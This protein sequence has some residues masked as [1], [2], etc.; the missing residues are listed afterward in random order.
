M[1]EELL[2][3][4]VAM[5]VTVPTRRKRKR[6]SWTSDE[7]RTFLESARSAQDPMY[8]VY[9]LILTIGLR[10]GEVLG[11][12]WNDVDLSGETLAV[13]HQ[14][15]RVHG[16]L[17]HRATK[18][19]ESEDSLPLVS[20][21]TAALRWQY[22]AQERAKRAAGEAWQ[23]GSWVFTT[24][25]GTPIEPRNFSRYFEARCEAA[26]VPRITVHDAR[27]TCATLLVDLDVHPRVIMR[28]LR[29]TQISMTMDIYAQASSKATREALRQLGNELD[30]PEAQLPGDGLEGHH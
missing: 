1:R 24:R 23:P 19:E 17:Y 9:V 13:N 25:Y 16:K 10:K 30:P 6:S 3:R 15:Q 21:G 4:N 29:H 18:T 8:A 7:A 11:L 22:A 2:S 5:S 28:I 26:G 14:L 12:L 27:R 20:L